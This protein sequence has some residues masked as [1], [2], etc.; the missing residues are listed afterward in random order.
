MERHEITLDIN[1][2]F[3]CMNG[4]AFICITKTHGLLDMTGL[5]CPICLGPV[6]DFETSI[7]S[8]ILAQVQDMGEYL[9]PTSDQTDEEEKEEEEDNNGYNNELRE[10]RDDEPPVYD[11]DI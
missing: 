8:R 6:K 9:T 1:V 7:D 5:L 2:W 3:A 11:S 4:H 10:R